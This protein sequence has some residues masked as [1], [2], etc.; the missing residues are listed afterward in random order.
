MISTFL[1]LHVSTAI[2]AGA[3]PG[4]YLCEAPRTLHL[5]YWYFTRFPPY[6]ISNSHHLLH[7]VIIFMRAWPLLRIVGD[8]PPLCA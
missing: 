7:V 5:L 6:H 1:P 3:Q 8:L 4:M 2:P